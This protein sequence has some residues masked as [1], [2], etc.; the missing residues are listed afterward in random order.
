M[1][2]EKMQSIPVTTISIVDTEN[3]NWTYNLQWPFANLFSPGLSL[4]SDKN[5]SVF[6]FSLHK[7]QCIF[8][9]E[10][11]LIKNKHHFFF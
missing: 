9:M 4:A 6:L 3:K 8:D 10:T 7:I 11:T 1:L 2:S 5:D